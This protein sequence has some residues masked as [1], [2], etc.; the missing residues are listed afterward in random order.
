M[1]D[2]Y[3]LIW[4]MM[5]TCRYRLEVVVGLIAVLRS[6]W[7]VSQFESMLSDR[8][9]HWVKRYKTLKYNKV[10]HQRRLIFISIMYIRLL[11]DAGKTRIRQ[12]TKSLRLDK[13]VFSIK[14]M[15]RFDESGSRA[16]TSESETWNQGWW[17]SRGDRILCLS[18]W[19]WH[20]LN[21]TDSWFIITLPTAQIDLDF[22]IH[23][24]GTSRHS[25]T[26][27][28]NWR[29]DAANWSL[30][31]HCSRQDSLQIYQISIHEER[32]YS[33]ERF[34]DHVKNEMEMKVAVFIARVQRDQNTMKRSITS[35]NKRLLL[36]IEKE[37]DSFEYI[38]VKRALLT[39]VFLIKAPVTPKG[40][41]HPESGN[42]RTIEHIPMSL[43]LS[44]LFAHHSFRTPQ[45]IL[46]NQSRQDWQIFLDSMGTDTWLLFVNGVLHL[47]NS[48]SVSTEK[49]T[50]RRRE[51]DEM[52]KK[53]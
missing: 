6:A 19:R 48:V 47:I 7:D 28:W 5:S 32:R 15:F 52:K 45:H 39:E 44:S 24:D 43:C 26:S 16:Q 11:A 1:T 20:R 37:D 50:R 38:R 10:Y 12:K 23:E 18:L 30:T 53:R 49:N 34:V 9:F 51:R 25:S 22:V 36:H 4:Q 35:W 27:T 13:I 46:R 14:K 21:I 41:S 2:L 31:T 42:T 17:L 33:K 8:D 29:S 3:V 40:V